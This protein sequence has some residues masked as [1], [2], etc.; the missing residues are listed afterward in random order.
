MV[1]YQQ[2]IEVPMLGALWYE[3]GRLR[4][5]TLRTILIGPFT[6]K[7]FYVYSLGQ[8][9]GYTWSPIEFHE[10]RGLLGVI[11][12]NLSVIVCYPGV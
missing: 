6:S 10:L 5:C 12:K 7:V 1:V 9:Y 11:V 2:F 8:G 4:R 3:E